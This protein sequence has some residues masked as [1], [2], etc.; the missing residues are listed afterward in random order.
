MA[1]LAA[2]AGE[3]T[4]QWL[5]GW[6]PLSGARSSLDLLPVVHWESPAMEE[7]SARTVISSYTRKLVPDRRKVGSCHDTAILLLRSGKGG[8]SSHP[9]L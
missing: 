3:V 6:N 5:Q 2:T 7:P 9:R 4:G 1:A 8:F